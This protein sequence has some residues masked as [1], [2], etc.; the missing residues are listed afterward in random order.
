MDVSNYAAVGD[1][2]CL[3]KSKTDYKQ[4]DCDTFRSVYFG[5]AISIHMNYLKVT[6]I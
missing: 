2:V 6:K 4:H 5:E 1:K 3:P